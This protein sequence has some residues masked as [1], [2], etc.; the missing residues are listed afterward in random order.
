[1][2]I[3]VNKL[4]KNVHVHTLYVVVVGAPVVVE[5]YDLCGVVD[6]VNL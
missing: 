6:C 1:L 5:V 4:M 3:N 2:V